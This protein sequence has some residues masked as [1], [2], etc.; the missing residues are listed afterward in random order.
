MPEPSV[1]PSPPDDAEFLLTVPLDAQSIVLAAS[2]RMAKRSL[3]DFFHQ[4]VH[5]M[6]RLK[7]SSFV[8]A[9]VDANQQ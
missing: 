5:Y 1:D 6:F 8:N 3:R 4:N 2:D 7:M 9:L